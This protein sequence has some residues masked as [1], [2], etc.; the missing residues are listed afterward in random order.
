M[1]VSIE[2]LELKGTLDNP[3]G[4]QLLQDVQAALQSDITVIL[5]DCQQVTFMDSGG[6]AALVK[7]VKATQAAGARFCL[8]SMRDQVSMLLKMTRMENIFE[9]FEDRVQFLG[10]MQQGL[11]DG[12]SFVQD[13]AVVPYSSSAASLSVYKPSA[14]N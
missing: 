5:L 14:T 7:L 12:A 6:L 2:V 10:V 9:I 13:N 11:P 8:C 4:Q 3:S 1:T